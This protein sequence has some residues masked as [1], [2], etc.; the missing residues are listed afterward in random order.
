VNGEVC[1]ANIGRDQRA[2]RKRLGVASLAGGALVF[3]VAPMLGLAPWSHA[4][5]AILL[6][7]G[8]TGIFQAREHT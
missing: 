7:G 8:F 1:I 6:Y 4:V 5:A 3:A 2:L